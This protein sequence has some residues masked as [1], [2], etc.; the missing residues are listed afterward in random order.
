ME[1]E[2]SAQLSRSFKAPKFRST[3]TFVT[4]TQHSFISMAA[5][6]KE[7]LLNEPQELAKKTAERARDPALPTDSFVWYLG[8][9]N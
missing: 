4:Q 7:V 3:F 8:N 9:S 1:P 6:E 2:I 5:L